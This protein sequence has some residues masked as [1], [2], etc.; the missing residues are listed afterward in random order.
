MAQM[1]G[2]MLRDRQEYG[3]F[4]GQSR[5]SPRVVQIGSMLLQLDDVQPPLP[6]PDAVP[7]QT[8]M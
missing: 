1:F 8:E 5:T 3:L 7:V 4:V 2:I 6:P